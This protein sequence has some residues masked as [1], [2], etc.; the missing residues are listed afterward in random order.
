MS[1]CGKTFLFISD[2]DYKNGN[3]TGAHKRFVEL[4]K[5]ASK[6]NN[7]ILVSRNIPELNGYDNINNYIISKKHSRFIPSHIEKIIRISKILCKEKK[8]VSYDYAV[9]FGPVDTFCYGINGYKNITTLFREDFIGYKRLENTSGIKIWYFKLLEGYAVRHSKKIIVQCED[10]KNALIERHGKKD[11]NLRSKIHVQINNVNAS[12]MK[13]DKKIK[14][15]NDGIVRIVFIGNF[16]DDRKGHQLLLPAIKKI[17]DDGYKIKLYIA[18]DGKQIKAYQDEYNEYKE[19][20]FLGRVKDVSWYLLESDFEL[21]PSLIDS[22]P[23]TVLEGINCG[24]AVYG[25]NVGGIKDILQDEDYLFGLSTN[26]IYEFVKNK[27]DKKEY[28]SDASNQKR[29]K[30]RLMFDWSERIMGLIVEGDN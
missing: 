11:K 25:T 30:K 13:N 12:W 26:S 1:V 21:V 15:R 4:V 20:V 17:I 9:S 22:C 5:G 23:N 18:G 24:I 2:T 7:V 27:I 29:I 14:K 6:K 3:V 16:S 19:I 10:D 28:V 8:N